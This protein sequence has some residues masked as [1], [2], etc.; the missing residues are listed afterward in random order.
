MSSG[1]YKKIGQQ[2]LNDRADVKV[3]VDYMN[4]VGVKI[5]LET[6]SRPIC[7]PLGQSLRFTVNS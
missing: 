3:A 7:S 4:L 2:L 5:G 1:Y 6:V